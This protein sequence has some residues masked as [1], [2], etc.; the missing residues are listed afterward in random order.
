MELDFQRAAPSRRFFQITFPTGFVLHHSVQ[1]CKGCFR[2]QRRR[3]A[4]LN[5]L[6]LLLLQGCATE[7]ELFR[8]TEVMDPLKSA[9]VNHFEGWNK[10][11]LTD[12]PSLK[13]T[14]VIP[15]A[16][17][18]LKPG[19]THQLT[20]LID[21]GLRQ[22]PLTRK[23]WEESRAAAAGLGIAES[24]WLPALEAQISGGYWRTPFPTPGTAIALAGSTI[25]P[26][27]HLSWT[28]FDRG[29][30]PEIERAT[31][32]LFASNLMVNRNLQDVTYQIQQ[33]YY[34]LLA[35][36]A[37]V[38]AAEV[39]LKQSTRNADAIGAQLAN[40]LATRPEHLLAIQDQARSAYELQEARGQVMQ[41]EA[42]LAQELGI[43]PDHALDLQTLEAEELPPDSEQSA[44]EIIDVALQQRPD[45]AARLAE[46]RARDAEI[47]KAEATYWPQFSL[48]ADGGWKLWNYY[49]AASNSEQSGYQDVKT[50]QP[51]IDGYLQM[52]WNIFEG[53]AGVNTIKQAEAKRNVAQA[54]FDALQ[55]KI[56]KETWK[57][58]AD[59]KTSVRK[60]AF[61]LAMLKASENAYEGALK[62]YEHGIATVI[63]LIT[64]E[65]NLA[66]ARY[67]DIDS[68]S[69]LLLA[70][71]SLVYANGTAGNSTEA[72][73]IP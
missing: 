16:N 27:L 25:Y 34:D 71:A 67:T 51:L 69:S 68:R 56:I 42:S 41:K 19:H 23:A 30:T 64:A 10:T 38:S 18:L 17:T 26:T 3:T 63:E 50:S 44:D 72:A 53:F 32:Q 12:V 22:N 31:Q 73:P 36:R 7:P 8:V 43:R 48:G 28:L 57:A 61:A 52:N 39:T 20:E 15:S 37:R 58:Y 29:R 2:G 13:T 45:L 60:R 55:L 9:P 1:M 54:T 47:R 65:R 33:N 46:L 14:Q 11:T 49:N 6:G 40:G 66:Q 4:R 24:A 5:I 59:F 21:F 62:S 70:A 35:A